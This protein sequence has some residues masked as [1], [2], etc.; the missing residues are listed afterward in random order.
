MLLSYFKKT[1]SLLE[2]KQKFYALFVLFV[3]L[4]QMFLELFS[5]TL[6]IPLISFLTESDLSKNTFYLFFKDNFNVN[7]S[8]LLKNFKIFI[9]FF[10]S[11]FLIRSLIILFCNWIKIK[12]A[13]DIRIF[14]IKKLYKKYLSLPYQ[15]F[16]SKNSSHYIKN[17]NYENDLVAEGVFHFLEFISEIII[18]TGIFIFL[19]FF[20]LKFSII[21]FLMV[22]TFFVIANLITRK[23]LKTLGDNVRN[24]E[25]FRLKNFI[26]SF[27]LIK[28]IKIFNKQSFFETRNKNFNLFLNDNNAVWKFLRV[29]PSISLELILVILISSIFFLI[30]GEYTIQETLTLLGVFLASALRLLPSIRK[31]I[32]S[33]QYFGFSSPATNNISNE[34]SEKDKLIDLDKIKIKSL[35]KDIVFSNLEFKYEN[36]DKSILKN[37]NL[38]ISAGKITGI[39]GSTGS[40]KSTIVDLMSGLIFPTSGS[41]SIDQINYN[42]IDINSLHGIIGYVP[43]NIYLMDASIKDN[44]TFGAETIS[45]DE[46][47]NVLR[48]TNL[49]EFINSLPLKIEALIGEKNSKISGGQAQRI[50]IARALIKQPSI[51][52]L[53]EATNSLDIETEDQILQ[54]I[55]KLKEETT[56]VIISHNE[57]SL[58]ICD[59]IINIDDHKKL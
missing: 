46:I 13:L 32:S 4:I 44:I 36:S 2:K 20:N 8:Y 27:N 19:L 14:L 31:I 17:M 34:L 5:V 23:K 40:G 26:E 24:F 58:K 25:Q 3:F 15:K 9:I 52:I 45:D 22:A 30:R 41:L 18:I 39:K 7:L 57:N 49:E 35:K 10:I 53:D 6:F 12:F 47:K 56:I 37:F 50:G 48:K 59:E 21:S 42:K 54:E 1:F 16:I 51:L 11:I 43:Q 38:K 33:V 55:K 28:E 29:I